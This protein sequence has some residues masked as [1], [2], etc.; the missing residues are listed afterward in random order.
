MEAVAITPPSAP[1]TWTACPVCAGT[2]S[3]T[4]V[5]FPQVAFVRCTTCTTVYKQ[6]E[7]PDIRPATF[8]EKDYFQGRKS[9]R[10]KRFDHR[11]K[12]AMRW[13]KSAMELGPTR[14]MLDVGC[15]L[16]YVVAAG[17]QLGLDSAG[18]D[19]SEYAVKVCRERGLRAEVGTLDHQPFL[20]GSFDLITMKHVLEHTPT[21]NVAL[22]EIRRLLSPG[23][24]V[25]VAVP[26]LH[27]WKGIF[28]R[29]SYRYFRPDDLGQQHYVY[30]TTE[31]MTRL[32]EA[33][34]FEVL[35]TS[36]AFY[37]PKLASHSAAS[38]VTEAARCAAM[39]VGYGVAR[40]LLQ[41]REL[42]IIARMR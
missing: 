18:S 23:G 16:G 28:L 13:I 14:S 35:V 25:L 7:T 41:Q 3:T 39:S 12:K 29:R 17:K 24:R 30:Y 21:P 2:S 26:N 4:Y 5:A 40:G 31:T 19:I 37:R 10:D 33:N 6:F 20:D 32:L 36:K 9:G 34:G 27:Y 15:S 8:Y 38:Q 1:L 22:K 11:V 42:F